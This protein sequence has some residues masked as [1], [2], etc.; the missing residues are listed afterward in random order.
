[1]SREVLVRARPGSVRL[2][3]AGS[4]V[5]AAGLTAALAPATAAAKGPAPVKG[6]LQQAYKASYYHA[7]AAELD[8]KNKP[9]RD[10][11]PLVLSATYVGH[12]ALEPTMGITK[13][14]NAF[15]VAAD[16]D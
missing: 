10:T 15:M 7:G 9:I 14:G 2:L 3:L 1:M 8:A 16:F 12:K 5:A 11:D 6:S 13:K 4:V